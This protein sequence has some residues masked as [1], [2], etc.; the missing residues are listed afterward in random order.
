[1]TLKTK[2]REFVKTINTDPRYAT[3]FTTT[4]STPQ[5]LFS[6][7][8]EDFEEILDKDKRVLREIMKE[9]DF[10]FTLN[11]TYEE[12]QS[13]LSSHERFLTLQPKHIPHL[14]EDQI[15]KAEVK[16]QGNIK[17][18]KKL[19]SAFKDVMKTVKEIGH[20]STW[21]DARPLLMGHKEFD[22][23][24][25]EQE[26]EKAFNEYIAYI[27]RKAKE[28]EEKKEKDR[29]RD[30]EKEKEKEKDRDRGDKRDRDRQSSDDETEE[31]EEREER[32]SKRH[33]KDKKKRQEKE[34]APP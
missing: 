25:D 20:N 22:A 13:V 14:Y 23:V 21:I 3:M 2:W 1:L 27:V 9:I 7:F 30:K 32:S 24:D 34:E 10:N 31:G 6:D 18:K 15:E 26:R 4:G 29:E 12:F 28:K 17:R 5:E 16:E 19:V 11:T 33:H 8:L